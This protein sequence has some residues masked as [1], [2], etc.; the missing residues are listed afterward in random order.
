MFPTER[1]R[2]LLGQR[3]QDAQGFLSWS[4]RYLLCGEK[5]VYSW[6]FFCP[7]F[8]PYL[9]FFVE[10]ICMLKLDTSI[11]LRLN[12]SVGFLQVAGHNLI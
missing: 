3:I 5:K 9:T 12:F 4:C 11:L 10:Q 1:R 7:T 6:G 2:T 8:I